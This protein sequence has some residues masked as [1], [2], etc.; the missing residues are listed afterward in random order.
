MFYIDFKIEITLFL[1][2]KVINIKINM[3]FTYTEFLIGFD[4]VLPVSDDIIGTILNFIDPNML[5]MIATLNTD[6]ESVRI[7]HFCNTFRHEII[8][9]SKKLCQVIRSLSNK[10]LYYMYMEFIPH[11][12]EYDPK[13]DYYMK[14][15]LNWHVFSSVFWIVIHKSILYK[16]KPTKNGLG[17]GLGHDQKHSIEIICTNGY[18]NKEGYGIL[19]NKDSVKIKNVNESLCISSKLKYAFNDKYISRKSVFL[20]FMCCDFV[21]KQVPNPNI[22]NFGTQ[23]FQCEKIKLNKKIIIENIHLFE[24]L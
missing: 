8:N 9:I 19:Y 22:I 17:L 21:M 5:P 14:Q 1:F 15:I 16:P 20:A 10:H 6:P 13:I 11:K 12:P 2:E 4:F 23:K 18:K 3:N 24:E 7:L